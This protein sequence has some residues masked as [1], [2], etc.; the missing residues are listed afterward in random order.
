MQKFYDLYDLRSA[1]CT[2]RSA[3]LHPTGQAL[4]NNRV[5]NLRVIYVL[6]NIIIVILA[7]H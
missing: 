5:R 1:S 7:L 2:L 4:D 3:F 6:R